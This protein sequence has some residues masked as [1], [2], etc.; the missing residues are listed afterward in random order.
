MGNSIKNSN[1]FGPL[2]RGLPVVFLALFIAVFAAKEYLRYATPQFESTAK[3]K[4]ADVHEGIPDSKLFKDFD[5][6]ASSNKLGAEVELLKSKV[7]LRKVIAK[8]P[9]GITIYRIGGLRKTELYTRAPFLIKAVIHDRRCYDIPF[10]INIY[11]D[12]LVELMTDSGGS[13]KGSFNHVINIRCASFI[14]YRNEPL[15]AEN[16]DL[17]INDRFQF[18]VHSEN[19]LI[20][21]IADNLDVM[22]V[23]KDIA[24]MRIS[25]K[26]PVPQKAADV[27]NTLSAAYITDYIEEKYRSADT[28][29]DFLDKQLKTYSRSLSNSENDI[30]NYRNDHNIINIQQETETDLRKIADLKKQLAN[31]KMNLNAVDSLNNY[32]RLGKDRF[33]QLAPN[34]EE[35]TDLLSTEMVK[36]IEELQRDKKDL[37][38]KYTP[39]NEKV[40]VV[41]NKLDDIVNYLQ[42]SIR[43][44]ENSL[45]IKYNNLQQSIDD[46]QKVFVGLPGREKNMGILDR[47]FG[48]NDQIYRF[49]HEKRT[50][51]QIAK[52]ATISFHRI[53]SEGDVPEKPVSPNAIIITILAAILGLAGG[54]A[55]I[56]IV[57]AVKGRVSDQDII[58]RLSDTQVAAAVPFLKKQ[59]EKA[60]F[61]KIWVTQLELK[62]ELKTGTVIAISSFDK[63]E[64]KA[65]ISAAMANEIGTTD[66][67][68]LFVD[69]GEIADAELLK[70]SNWKKHIATLRSNY[71]LVLIKN[72]PV[73]EHPSAL[74][75]MTNADLNLFLL[76]SR[77]TKKSVIPDADLLKEELRLPNM[78]FVLNRAGYTPSLLTQGILLQKELLKKIG[79]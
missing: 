14:I 46:A 22:S 55:L 69:A 37:L 71:D 62:D 45:R 63:L 75:I 70:P 60:R 24:V 39:Q 13:V 3:I 52:A 11:K 40:K 26:C 68:Y 78:Q 34:F 76:D 74:V 25:Y 33:L 12:S 17:K 4:L 49:L 51:A 5:V 59:S 65:F 19:K 58:N 2:Y 56:Y 53:I 27:V 18:V 47:N 36:K 28:T 10:R 30:E 8:L 35:F 15:F 9:L 20:S 77:C 6:F 1:T 79:R 66:K 48:L 41:D 38:L 43:N 32:L 73:N 57:H 16:P 7:L 50:E 21:S 44:S 31:V 72:L 42:E 23:D 29:E 64:G 61:F 67:K 54:I